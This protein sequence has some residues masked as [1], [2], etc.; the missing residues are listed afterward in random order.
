[1]SPYNKTL[2]GDIFLTTRLMMGR[3]VAFKLDSFPEHYFDLLK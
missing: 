3:T 1:M 2:Y